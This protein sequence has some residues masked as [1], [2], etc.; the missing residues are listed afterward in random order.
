VSVVIMAS[1]T[2][3]ISFPRLS[4]K[5]SIEFNMQSTGKG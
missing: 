4:V 5:S 1:D 2:G 3:S